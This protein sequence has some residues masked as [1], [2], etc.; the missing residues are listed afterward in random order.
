MPYFAMINEQ[1]PQ[2]D[3]K[4]GMREQK[5]WTEHAAFMDALAE[6]GFIV[7]GGPLKNYAKHRTL[8][9]FQAPDEETVRTRF[10]KDN[11]IRDGMLKTLEIYRW[12]ILLGELR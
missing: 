8:L 10:A 12:E 11:W 5:G 3:S 1:G 6:E 7:L 9:I 4:L 2:W